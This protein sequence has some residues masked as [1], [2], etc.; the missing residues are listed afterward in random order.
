M[1]D[2]PRIKFS[3]HADV[4]PNK[5][6]C[7]RTALEA[8][9]FNVRLPKSHFLLIQNAQYLD[10]PSIVSTCRSVQSFRTKMK[11]CV[12]NRAHDMRSSQ[13]R[14]WGFEDR[15]STTRILIIIRVLHK[16]KY[17]SLH[18]LEGQVPNVETKTS[19]VSKCLAGRC[20]AQCL[21]DRLIK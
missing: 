18:R 15:V 14:G 8:D 19:A 9:L 4:L 5:Y 13:V 6:M 17:S 21:R 12:S 2:S 3:S 1:R 7:V 16:Y 10:S 11:R 20:Q